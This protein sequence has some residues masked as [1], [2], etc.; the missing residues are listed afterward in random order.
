MKD[1]WGREIFWIGGGTI[2]WTGR[3]VVISSAPT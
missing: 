2:T 3:V 1:P